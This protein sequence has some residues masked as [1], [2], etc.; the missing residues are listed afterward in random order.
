MPIYEYGCESCNVLIEKIES[1]G[2]NVSLP[3]C[4]ECGKRM[5]RLVSCPSSFVFKGSGFYD[6]EYDP[7]GRHWVNK[8][9]GPNPSKEP[10]P[11]GFDKKK[12]CANGP[13]VQRRKDMHKE[14]V[15]DRNRNLVES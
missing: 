6:T 8:W 1:M 9:A 15:Q 3:P 11:S 5:N 13:E 7:T 12:W 4:S 14:I 2:S 10:M